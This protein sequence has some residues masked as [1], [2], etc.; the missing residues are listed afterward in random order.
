M[1][2]VL[3]SA[4]IKVSVTLDQLMRSVFPREYGDRHELEETET[5]AGAE[6]AADSFDS[7]AAAAAAAA[8]SVVPV[9]LPLFVLDS[10][11]PGQQMS[12]N[13][14]EPRYAAFVGRLTGW[15]VSVPAV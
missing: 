11:L 3:E 12:L 13:I 6:A 14:F 2:V 4:D 7:V 1:G 10:M 5:K 15:L 9:H 8:S